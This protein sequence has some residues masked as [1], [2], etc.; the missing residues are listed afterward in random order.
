MDARL[1]AALVC[2]LAAVYVSYRLLWATATADGHPAFL[3]NSTAGVRSSSD[4]IVL[5]GVTA[6]VVA[7][8]LMATLAATRTKA[9]SS[10]RA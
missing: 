8:V 7:I 1:L 4:V 6:I 10:S 3:L 9:R 2:Y 5:I